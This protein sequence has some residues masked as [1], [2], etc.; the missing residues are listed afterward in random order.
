MFTLFICNINL[1]LY[2]A[3]MAYSCVLINSYYLMG[4]TF[5]EYRITF[6]SA[7]YKRQKVILEESHSFCGSQSCMFC[8]L[9]N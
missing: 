2:I 7:E 8:F 3:G 6:L 5:L 1:A 4:E 9:L